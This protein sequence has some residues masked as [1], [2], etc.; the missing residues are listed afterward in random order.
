[1]SDAQERLEAPEAELA[2]LDEGRAFADR[3]GY[4]KLSVAGADTET[5]LNDLLTA[6]LAG[7][8]EG[9]ARRSLLLSPTGR[10]RADVMAVGGAAG[11]VLLQDPAQDVAVG[12]L[13]APYVLSS[14][15]TLTDVTEQLALYCIPGTLPDALPSPGSRPSLLGEGSDLLLP[16]ADAPRIEAMLIEVGL[17]RVGD[18]ALEVRRIRRGMP[19]FPIDVTEGSVPAE[20]GLEELIDVTKGCFLGQESVAKIRNLGHPAT[21]VRAARTEARVAPGAEVL[22]DRLGVGRVTSA[23]AADDGGTACLLRIAWAARD[24]HLA[25]ADGTPLTA[26]R[27]T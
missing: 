19:R 7:L 13:L 4:R 26:H 3:S 22:A 16:A 2:A 9:H 6:G 8:R 27:S 15:V 20:A 17:A 12:D 5:W 21:L 18:D 10:I 23:A 14:A 1:M 25:T 24:A 11:V